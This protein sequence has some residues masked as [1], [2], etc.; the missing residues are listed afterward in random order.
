MI[1][2]I[3]SNGWVFYS[4]D[5]ARV[6]ITEKELRNYRDNDL[7]DD[8]IKSFLYSYLTGISFMEFNSPSFQSYEF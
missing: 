6:N 1:P 8:Q 2:F 3:F 4:Q 7:T 5:G